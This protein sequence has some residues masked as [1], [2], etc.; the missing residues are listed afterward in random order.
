M[1]ETPDRYA[2]PGTT[3]T[4]SQIISNIKNE[5]QRVQ[6]EKNINAEK[7]KQRKQLQESV[8][9]ED[10]WKSEKSKRYSEKAILE[11]QLKTLYTQYA[12]PPYSVEET[13]ILN[14]KIAEIDT[15]MHKSLK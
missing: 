2:R 8:Q 12:P 6:N 3:L 9:S 13:T 5:Q 11:S 7:A 15:K 10:K 1:A 4:T 14:A